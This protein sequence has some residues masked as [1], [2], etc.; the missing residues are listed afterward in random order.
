MPKPLLDDLVGAARID[1]GRVKLSA[2]ALFWLIDEQEFWRGVVKLNNH[3]EKSPRID[4]RIPPQPLP[5]TQP[6][7][8]PKT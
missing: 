4:V 2:L 1:G 8:V 6:F 3:S 5:R 7:L